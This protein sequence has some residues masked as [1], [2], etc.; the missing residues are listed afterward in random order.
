MNRP[1]RGS[2]VIDSH[3]IAAAA[4]RLAAV[5]GFV[6]VV[7]AARV[8]ISGGSRWPPFHA[9]LMGTALLAISG[10]TQMFTITWSTSPAP[11][12][13]TAKAQR[14]SIALGAALVLIGLPN[15][16]DWLVLVG[17]TLLLVGLAL[18]GS[19]LVSIIRRSL[20]RRFDL[21][22]RFYLLAFSSGMVGI[23]LGI[24]LG[25]GAESSTIIR[26]AHSRLNLIGLLGFT[27]LGTLPTLLPTLAHSKPVAGRE[28]VVALWMSMVAA[29]LFVTG[30]WMGPETVGIGVLVAG[31]ALGAILLGSVPRL[32][33]EALRSGLPYLQ[34]VLGG[35]W[36][37]A[38][39][40]ADGANLIRGS[41]SSSFAPWIQAAVVAGV[42]QVM[43]GSLAYLAPVLVGPPPRLGR[44]LSRMAA[45]SWL[46]LA[47]ANL[48]GICFV[49]GWT[50]AAG[51]AAGLWLLDFLVRLARLEWRSL[52]E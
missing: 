37:I 46:P 13:A 35:L 44:N 26:I 3:R 20:L 41:V 28:A 49:V 8:F 29:L 7:W 5:F 12:A 32:G 38:W 43:L 24:M 31:G 18:L 11:P 17:G 16:I 22:S 14:W 51:V 6:A 10:L 4:L 40:M 30:I 48:A 50:I 9:F 19:S 36:L 34:V 52:D 45:H 39:T 33:R 1:T 47:L 23:L 27:I 21:S 25:T 2:R 42:V 15:A